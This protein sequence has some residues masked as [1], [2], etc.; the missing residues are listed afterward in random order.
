MPRPIAVTV[1]FTLPL[2]PTDAYLLV[3]QVDL[4]DAFHATAG[5]PAVTATTPLEGSWDQAGA[6][7]LVH[8]DGGGQLTEEVLVASAPQ[9]FEYRIADF[10]FVLRHLATEGHGQFR[11][12]PAD[13]GTK[14]AW[15]YTFTPTSAATAPLVRGFA[16]LAWRRY[17]AAAAGRF[18]ELSR[19]V[20]PSPS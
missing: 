18:A 14:V 13:G 17:M 6:R 5:V 15:T 1:D 19:R 4:P 20:D 3:T 10:T 16:G 8:V 11:F 7:R 12:A 2:P 9:R